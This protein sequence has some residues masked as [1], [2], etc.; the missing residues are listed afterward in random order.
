MPLEIEAFAPLDSP[1]LCCL[2]WF[3]ATGMPV[4]PRDLPL[5]LRHRHNERGNVFRQEAFCSAPNGSSE[6]IG[7]CSR[8]DSRRRRVFNLGEA[9]TESTSTRPPSPRPPHLR[10]QVL[11]W[12]PG[13]LQKADRLT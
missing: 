11:R 4:H 5:H 10:A 7:E 8:R 1:P 12:A 3:K 13:S 6:V 9:A 2:S